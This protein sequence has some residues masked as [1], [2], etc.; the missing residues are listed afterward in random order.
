[1]AN[2]PQFPDDSPPPPQPD[3]FE[4]LT[5]LAGELSHDINNFLTGILGNASMVLRKLGSDSDCR[6]MVRDIER[7]ALQAAELSERMLTFAGR[8]ELESRP[9]EIDR[10]IR[11]MGRLIKLS[12]PG[13]AELE[14]E[15]DGDLPPVQG[16]G[17]K[18][19]DVLMQLLINAGEALPEGRGSVTLATGVEELGE[20]DESLPRVAC[21]S[22]PGP[23][24]YFEVR[25]QGEGMD[26]ETRRRLFEPFFSRKSNGRG[27]GLA[28]VLGV[29]RSHGGA[30][31]IASAPGRGTRCRVLLP[32]LG[33]VE[34]PT[35]AAGSEL[36][37]RPVPADPD[38][39]LAHATVMVVDDEEIVRALAE[40][41]LEDTGCGVL[42]AAS[43]EEAL[44]RLEAAGPVDVV[45]LDVTMPGMGGV[46]TFRQMR[47][48]WPDLRILLQSGHRPDD[49]EEQLGGPPSGF[50]RKPYRPNDLI[51]AL[52]SLVGPAATP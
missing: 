23:Y 5:L 50:I 4:G 8:T 32:V 14:L 35:P 1:M 42:C 15:L 19:R 27:L 47:R 40:S 36:G 31:R 45:V 22:G 2:D 48:R 52:E 39:P 51:E 30:I 21:G 12:I 10:L 26:D 25:D 41:I 13:T 18:L 9:V 16:D 34:G 37:P 46:E 29:V 28:V 20:D 17:G 7:A 43:G 3:A 33:A 6:G 11:D 44:D 38:E 24:V 49:I